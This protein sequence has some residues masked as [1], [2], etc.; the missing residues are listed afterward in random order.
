MLKNKIRL[1][2][3][4][5]KKNYKNLNFNTFLKKKNDIKCDNLVMY[6]IDI[7]FFRKNISLHIMDS[8]GVLK[9]FCS[10]GDSFYR[11]MSKKARLLALKSI[12]RTIVS[13][14]KFLQKKPVVLHLKNVRFLKLWILKKLKKKFFIK[15]IRSFNLYPHN[16][17]RK[18]KIRRKK[19]K[20]RQKGMAEWFKAADC[21][22][23]E[24]SHRRFESYFLYFIGFSKY[25][26]AVACL[27]WE[28][29]AMC[30]NHIISIFFKC[31]L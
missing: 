21:K 4:I 17:C 3:S 8:S 14:L 9:F 29:E 25:N 28:Q 10:A 16:G 15:V 2:I 13:K 20:K 27:L 18:R 24:F 26:A 6:I 30:S 11:K 12:F 22:S 1:L 31:P 7:C 23:V 5:K 19:F